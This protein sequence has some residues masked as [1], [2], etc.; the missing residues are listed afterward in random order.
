MVS[1][2]NGCRALT[3]WRQPLRGLIV[4]LVTIVLAGVHAPQASGQSSEG[5]RESVTLEGSHTDIQFL[6]AR[7]VLIKA[8]VADDVFAA[9]RDVTFESATVKNAV[10]A[11][12]DVEFRSGNA[13]DMIAAA[14]NLKI[15]GAIEDD[16]VAAARSMRITSQ[17]TIGGD[18]RL[19][20]ETI[21]LEGRISGSVRAAARRIT[22]SGEI[23]G[24]ADLLAERI[25][26]APGAN[27]AGDLI[28]RSGAKPEIAEGATI[29]GE[30][31]RVEVDMPDPRSFARAIVGIG[32]LIVFS[33]ALAMLL[34]IAVV[35]LVFPNFISDAAGDLQDHPWSNLGFGVA[36]HLLAVVL[37]GLFFASIV[38]IPI[39]AA[40]TMATAVVWL[41]GL[42][43]V[44]ACIG[45]FVR[46][47]LRRPVDIRPLGRI[48]WAIAGAIILG[49]IALVPFVGV[50]VV[51]L[52][53]AAGFGAAAAELWGRLRTT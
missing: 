32:L 44:S 11:G 4:L 33:W 41:L 8:K 6:A 13:T 47:R 22:I 42:V 1:I 3:V 30:I 40:L 29:G 45:L 50:V 17:G 37:G 14:A 2:E 10:V 27:I 36:I 53:V 25:V 5:E 48:G 38:G 49:L 52:A 26:I 35:Q 20:A 31:R 51:G 18:A 16:L 21:D 39:G 23:A 43:T 9:G 12:Y 28:Y 7:T 24:K 15:S 46:G 34:L 19:A